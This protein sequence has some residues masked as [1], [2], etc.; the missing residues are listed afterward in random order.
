MKDPE[1]TKLLKQCAKAA[2]AHHALM[3]LVAEECQRRYGCH[4]SDLDADDLIE[5]LDLLG[6]E[7]ITASQFGKIMKT[8]GA[9]RIDN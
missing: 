9:Q 6:D 8:Y 2:S 3:G 5:A 1:F 7:S 4:Y